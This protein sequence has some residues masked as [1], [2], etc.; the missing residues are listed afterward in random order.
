MPFL[1]RLGGV[2]SPTFRPQ[3]ALTAQVLAASVRSLN[4]LRPQAVVVTGDLADNAQANELD[5]AR[6]VL[7]GGRVRPDSGA[8]GL[9]RACRRR[10]TPTRFYYRPDNDPPR[11]PGLLAAAQRAFTRP[12]LDAPVVPGAR[13]PRPARPGRGAADA[14]DRGARHRRPGGRVARPGAAAAPRHG[15]EGGGRRAARRAGSPAARARSPPIPPAACSARPRRC[16]GSAAAGATAAGS[17]TRSTSAPS[18]RGIVLDVVDRARRSA[19]RR[20]AGAA[21]VA[22]RQSCAA[23]AAATSSS[24]PTSR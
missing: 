17:T 10:T 3:E 15:L 4:R 18:V 6:A 12:G 7:D 23:P 19:R 11:H 5:T 14:G 22:A 9:R 20:H 13:Q 21:R 24:S 8:P 1:D 2:F 16:G